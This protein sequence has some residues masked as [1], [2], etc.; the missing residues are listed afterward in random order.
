M[1]ISGST[2]APLAIDP[3]EYARRRATRGAAR[4]E[5]PIPIVR[6]R[7]AARSGQPGHADSVGKLSSRNAAHA[8][9]VGP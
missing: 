2:S 8:R 9:H 3:E 4:R 5:P 7:C 1:L 6:R